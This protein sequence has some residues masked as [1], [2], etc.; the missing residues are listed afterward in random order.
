MQEGQHRIRVMNC[1]HVSF[2]YRLWGKLG[3]SLRVGACV[4]DIGLM[5][6]LRNSGGSPLVEVAS[7]SEITRSA[8]RP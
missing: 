4:R 2:V 8:E 7:R 6:S 5:P 3:G 1:I